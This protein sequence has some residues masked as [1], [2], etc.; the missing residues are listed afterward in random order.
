M[1]K[2]PSEMRKSMVVPRWSMMWS[3]VQFRVVEFGIF[4]L[5]MQSV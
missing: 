1:I 4:L 3:L 5:E 2:Q